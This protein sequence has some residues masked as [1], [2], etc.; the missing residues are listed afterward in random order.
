MFNSLQKVATSYLRN[1]YNCFAFLY[2]IIYIFGSM[3]KNKYAAVVYHIVTWPHYEL[4]TRKLE[5]V[6]HFNSIVDL[7]LDLENF[8]VPERQFV[9]QYRHI[10]T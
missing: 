3:I 6:I 2:I 9:V 1:K 7:N 5:V 10:E 4:L 8:N